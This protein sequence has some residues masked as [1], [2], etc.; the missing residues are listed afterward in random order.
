MFLST[1]GFMAK[2]VFSKL[3][4]LLFCIAKILKPIL[5]TSSQLHAAMP[6]EH[7]LQDTGQGEGE[8]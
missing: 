8:S 4:K 2:D 7:V 6:T 1:L 5:Y 3:N